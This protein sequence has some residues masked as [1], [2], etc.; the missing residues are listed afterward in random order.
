MAAAE[1]AGILLYRRKGA[2]LEVLLVHPGGPY[3]RAKDAGAWTIP[4][5]VIDP[6]EEALAAAVRE[7]REETGVAVEGPFIALGPVKQKAGKVV[8]AFACEGD[9]DPAA[10]V[11]N[12]FELEWPPRSGRMQEF[13][14]VDRAGWFSVEAARIK[15]IAAQIPLVEELEAR[16]RA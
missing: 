10:I 4:K 6:G 1:S 3:W 11:S 2:S 9:C 8:T 14:E 7:M 12:T 13:P 5:G 15:L 16:L